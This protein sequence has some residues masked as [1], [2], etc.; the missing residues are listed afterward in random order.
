VCV[1]VCVRVR[2]YS[3]QCCDVYVDCED[4]VCVRR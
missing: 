2:R 3:R 4:S 1:C